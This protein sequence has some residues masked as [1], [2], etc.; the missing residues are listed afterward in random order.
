M[1]QIVPLSKEDKMEEKQ[2]NQNGMQ[3]AIIIL[4]IIMVIIAAAIA[5]A[6][7]WP[8]HWPTKPQPRPLIVGWV[9]A[10]IILVNLHKWPSI[11]LILSA[12]FLKKDIREG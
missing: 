8:E 6:L 4:L 9:S 3:T 10:F 2:Q 1:A 5:V 7:C 11:A 12:A